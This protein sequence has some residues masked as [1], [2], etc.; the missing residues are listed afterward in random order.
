MRLI[1][2]KKL[3]ILRLKRK[4]TILIKKR[5][6]KQTVETLENSGIRQERHESGIT[7]VL[8]QKNVSR[9]ECLQAM[10]EEE[11]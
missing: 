10:S 6:Y 9:R 3:R 2:A 11:L 5:V 8:E 7:N 1:F 4:N